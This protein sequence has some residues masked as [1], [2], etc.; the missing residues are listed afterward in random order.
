MA[1]ASNFPAIRPSLNL[2]FANARALDPRIT[3]SRAS[4]ATYYDGKTVAKAEE[5]LLKYSQEFGNAAWTKTG[6]VVTQS[7]TTAPDATVTASALIEDSSNAQHYIS[8]PCTVSAGLSYTFSVYFKA[9][10][11]N[12]GAIYLSVSTFP[13]STAV[14]FDLSS[15]T[16]TSAGAGVTASSTQSAGNGW[17]RISLTATCTT[18]GT[19]SS[20]TY[21]NNS[22][23]STAAYQGD[24]T[25]G[26]YVW[27]AQLEQR[28]QVTAYTPTTTQP[29]TNYIPVLQTAPANVPRIDHDPVTGECKGLLV[30]EQR[31]NLIKYSQN[32]FDAWSIYSGGAL[33]DGVVTAPDGSISADVLRGDGVD[34][35]GK[36]MN[37]ESV[38][39]GTYTLSVYVKK[40]T[41]NQTLLWVRAATEAIFLVQDTLTW[42]GGVP[43]A[44]G[45][46][47][48]HCGNDWYRVWKAF[49]NTQ[50]QTFNVYV[51]PSPKDTVATTV[52]WGAQL[53]AG[54][55]PTS[56][57]KTEASQV[58]RAADSA[59]MTGANFSSWYRQDEGALFADW[60]ASVS[61]TH[62]VVCAMT[63]GT[64]NNTFVMGRQTVATSFGLV[65]KASGA[66]QGVPI[67]TI[68]SFNSSNKSAAV[69]KTND[70]SIVTNG[71]APATD[72]LAVVPKLDRLLI[73]LPTDGSV[74]GM[75]NGHIRR[76][77]YHP[78]RLTDAQLQA[79]TA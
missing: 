46:N 41:S 71:G 67:T 75:Y 65:V 21:I 79:L 58:T 3:F 42:V 63:D 14:F 26:I 13:A 24:G 48:T 68:A 50:A 69:Y 10:G 17:F 23:N 43:Q 51:L 36:T 44:P 61:N 54:A 77:S 35:S 32:I 49:A 66:V 53:E 4:A 78:K 57:I 8:Q 52:F 70:F 76:I 34:Y 25:S 22:P 59:S 29:I 27:G 39:A 47:A 73:A 31:T 2:D 40:G 5:N 30:E 62:S 28:S 74:A 11:R 33:R 45:W 60:V 55:F 38:P 18:T 72:T 9:N 7:A 1:I 64:N 6:S 12:F 16:I 56:Y 19:G 15:G 20:A 37:V